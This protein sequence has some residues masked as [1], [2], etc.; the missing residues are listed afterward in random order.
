MWKIE[1]SGGLGQSWPTPNRWEEGEG[2][3]EENN[4]EDIKLFYII[5]LQNENKISIYQYIF[6][7]QTF[8]A[9]L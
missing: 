7:K 1:I 9:L 6:F 8:D 3:E 5:Y 4:E 2:E